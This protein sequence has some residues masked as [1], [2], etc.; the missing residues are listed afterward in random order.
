M[1]NYH[2]LNGRP[3]PLIIQNIRVFIFLEFNPSLLFLHA[4]VFA[5]TVFLKK[6]VFT[7]KNKFF[8]DD[9]REPF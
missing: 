8:N 4:P 7:T 5:L 2:P 6:L 9:A 1:N 3:P